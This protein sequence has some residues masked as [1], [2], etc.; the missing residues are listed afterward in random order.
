[1]I[2][3]AKAI[4][5]Q[6]AGITGTGIGKSLMV[7]LLCRLFSEDGYKVAPFKAL[8]LTNVVYRD[9]EGREFGYSQALQAIAAGIE[10]NYR[11]NPFTPK[12]LGNGE[13]ELILEGE[14]Y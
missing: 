5:I 3:K 10:P 13:F 7:A 1:M 8:N 11:M 14:G 2:V 6:A 9:G 4:A 12:P